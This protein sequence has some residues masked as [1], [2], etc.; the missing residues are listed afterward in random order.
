MTTYKTIE[1][2]ASR[3]DKCWLP[4]VAQIAHFGGPFN[5]RNVLRNDWWGKVNIWLWSNAYFWSEI[6]SERHYR[7]A[8]R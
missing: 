8:E 1:S 4:V 2:Y 3:W 5:V 7:K 6:Q